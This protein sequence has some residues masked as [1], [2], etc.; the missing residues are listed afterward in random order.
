MTEPV[1]LPPASRMGMRPDPGAFARSGITHV[2][3]LWHHDLSFFTRGTVEDLGPL[4]RRLRLVAEFSP[5][6]GPPAGV[7][8]REDAYY[9]PFYGF[10]G[11][12]RPGPL[13]RIYAPVDAS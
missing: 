5:F 2:V 3:T 10:G 6:A 13:V 7:F 11:V 1:L 8:E 12:V 4:A 9:V